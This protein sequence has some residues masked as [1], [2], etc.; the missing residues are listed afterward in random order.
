VEGLEEDNNNGVVVDV[1]FVGFINLMASKDGTFAPW[2]DRG[3]S[4]TPTFKQR[5]D[6]NGMKI[7]SLA[8]F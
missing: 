8:W 7:V 4:L 1:V 3:G 5:I 6:K 2:N